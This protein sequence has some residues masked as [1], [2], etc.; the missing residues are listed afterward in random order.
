MPL[1]IKTNTNENRT[2]IKD[3]AIGSVFEYNDAIYIKCYRNNNYLYLKLYNNI[4][5]NS[6]EFKNGI[7]EFVNIDSEASRNTYV[8]VL[9][10]ELTVNRV[11]TDADIVN[12]A[13]EIIDK[14]IPS[15]IPSNSI[16]ID[17]LIASISNRLSEESISNVTV[18]IH[19]FSKKDSDNINLGFISGVIHLSKN[20]YYR[21]IN[22]YLQIN[23]I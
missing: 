10:C 4:N 3:L 19:N 22:L 14:F 1:Q 8:N 5:D 2:L 11:I 7:F 12:K 20:N 17:S 9:D 23:T 13:H 15:I 18:E 21:S 16:T 6:S